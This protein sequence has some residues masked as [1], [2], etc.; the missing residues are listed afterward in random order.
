[1]PETYQLP[2]T[3]CSESIPVAIKMAG[4][5]TN[6]QHCDSSV[7]VPPMREIRRLEPA[8][9]NNTGS[10]Q[11][12]RQPA[13]R[14]ESGSWLFS[15]GLLLAGIATLAAV[16][17]WFYANSLQ[18]ASTV[19]DEIKI[20]DQVLTEATPGTVWSV[21][22]AMSE[23]GLPEWK[24]TEQTRYNKQAKILKTIASGIGVLSVLGLLMMIGSFFL[25]GKK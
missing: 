7:E 3:N 24:E 6:C 19:Q 5:T 9:E 25:K 18:T 1:M 21:W 17:L 4:R 11:V 20:N 15:S 22:T 23:S 12:N 14:S 13:K 16:S 8:V 2:C 10:N